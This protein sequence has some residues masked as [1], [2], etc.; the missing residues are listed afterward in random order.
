MPSPRYRVAFYTERPDGTKEYCVCDHSEEHKTGKSPIVQFDASVG[1]KTTFS[2]H[3]EAEKFA[4]L[5]NQR[6]VKDSY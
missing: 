2:E 6:G 4:A 5:L 3:S 1:W